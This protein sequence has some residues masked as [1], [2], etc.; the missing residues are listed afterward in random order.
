MK[1]PGV[2]LARAE[3]ELQRAS[4]AVAA[5]LERWLTDTVRSLAR[6]NPGKR[7]RFVAGNGI[8]LCDVDGVDR[9]P[10]AVRALERAHSIWG[11]DVIPAPLWLE[12]SDG[13]ATVT[14]KTEWGA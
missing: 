2:R 6:H 10:P 5:E 7:V 3:R 4:N 13:G 12:S 8:W 9:R 1:R 11:Y 14:R